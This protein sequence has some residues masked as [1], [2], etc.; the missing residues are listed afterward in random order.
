MKKIIPSLLILF[1]AGCKVVQLS[2]FNIQ[3]VLSTKL[4]AL[5]LL[6]DNK[7]SINAAY[8]AYPYYYDGGVLP[9]AAT[10]YSKDL[11]ENLTNPVGEKY[12]YAQFKT[13]V[14]QS[15][16]HGLGWYAL[17]LSTMDI[18]NILFGMPWGVGKTNLEVEMQILNSKKEMIAKYKAEGSA[19]I[20]IALYHG[21]GM[22]GAIKMANITAVKMALANI[23]AQVEKDAAMI[24]AKLTESGA[25][26]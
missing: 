14:A 16:M 6:S 22:M 2:D 8:P 15:G 26:K 10:L 12:G 13:L 4:P 11:E 5:E 23:N 1:C 17:S 24:K 19:K 25:I 9:D 21:Y 20:P 18:P 3:P 7:S